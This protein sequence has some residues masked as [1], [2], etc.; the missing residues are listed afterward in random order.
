M[1]VQLEEREGA[2]RKRGE[3]EGRGEVGEN[4]GLDHTVGSHF[5]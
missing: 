2:G 1:L 5:K 4:Q 3:G